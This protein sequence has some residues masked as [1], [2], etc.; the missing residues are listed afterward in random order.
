MGTK[1]QDWEDEG[2]AMQIRNDCNYAKER[3][4]EKWK[5]WTKGDTLGLQGIYH[6]I[7]KLDEWPAYPTCT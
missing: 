4:N 3:E 6:A 7:S 2:L 1:C 5:N